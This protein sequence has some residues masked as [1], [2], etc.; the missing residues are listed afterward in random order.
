MAEPFV[1]SNPLRGPGVAQAV[2]KSDHVTLR[3]KQKRW[4]KPSIDKAIKYK[5]GRVIAILRAD[6]R[7]A[8]RLQCGDER[9]R[10]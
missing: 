3:D 1:Q 6:T 10:N 8:T 4:Q 7:T 9:L 2:K 5:V